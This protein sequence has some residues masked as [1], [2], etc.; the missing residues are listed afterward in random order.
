MHEMVRRAKR[1]QKGFTLVELMV[2]VV[3]IGVLVAIAIPLFGGIQQNARQNACDANARIIR[4]AVAMFQAEGETATVPNRPTVAELVSNGY[5]QATPAPPEGG[6]YG[7][8]YDANNNP[9]VTGGM[10]P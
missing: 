4:G 10:Q 3:I 5:L 9:T 6:A 7:I 2:V 1:N 8:T